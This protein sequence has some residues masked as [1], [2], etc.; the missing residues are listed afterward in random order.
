M[1][2]GVSAAAIIAAIV[3]TVM[4]PNATYAQ[5]RPAS[6]QTEIVSVARMSET[7]RVFGQVVAERES[8][9][10]ARVPGIAAEIPVRVGSRVEGGDILARL[11]TELLQIEVARAET[12]LM[13]A[14]AGVLVAEA[15]LD[16]AL[17]AFGRAEN[18]RASANIS[19]ATLEERTSSL[20]E[21]RGLRQEA[22]A[23]IASARNAMDRA[24]Y[25]LRNATVRAPFAGVVLEVSTEIG[26]YVTAGSRVVTLLDLGQ[27][28]VQANIPAALIEA[29]RPDE[30][31]KG[32]TGTGVVLDLELRAILPTE[33]SATHTRPVLFDLIDSDANV[34]VGQSVTLDVPASAPRDVL[35]VPK[36]ALVQSR[37][38]W[39]VF[40]NDDGIA[41]PRTVEIGDAVGGSFEVL[42]GLQPG[43]E[44]VVRGNE[45]LRPG[46][47]IAPNNG[48]GAGTS[49][50]GERPPASAGAAASQ[51]APSPSGDDEE[52][53][54]QPAAATVPSGVDGTETARTGEL[55]RG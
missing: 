30:P 15:R 55:G 21:A 47:P 44:V 51:S 4:G 11:D 20:A 26:Q 33:F 37:D 40:V 19:D 50:G 45:R 49:D 17:K 9:V 10:A 41:A 32:T 39:S 14:E 18:L 52:G 24:Q 16:R 46:Q 28:E 54:L 8:E 23:R 12:E 3:F 13:I 7:S 2:F 35:V 38:G 31:V 22:Q 34:A 6:V 25:N 29:L 1:R 48:A 53:S 27:L 43:D 5:G 42:S 36:D